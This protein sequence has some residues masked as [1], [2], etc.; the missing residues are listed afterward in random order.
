M[1]VIKVDAGDSL[2]AKAREHQQPILVIRSASAVPVLEGGA[3]L[4]KPAVVLRYSVSF[5]KES[6]LEEWVFEETVFDDG[7]G[8]FDLSDTLEA[9]LEAEKDPPVFRVLNRSGSF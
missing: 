5:P 3:V 6:P 7:S 9:R 1:N 4:M 8:R 2:V